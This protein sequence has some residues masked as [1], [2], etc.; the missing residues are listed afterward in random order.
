MVLGHTLVLMQ[1]NWPA[2]SDNLNEISEMIQMRGGFS[3]PMFA[4]YIINIDILERF[5]F[6]AG[7]NGPKLPLD[8]F[9]GSQQMHRLVIFLFERWNFT[10]VPI[11]DSETIN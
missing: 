5:A 2:E 9:A 10:S 8:I 4:S 11:G 7:P 6:L 3:Y 1:L